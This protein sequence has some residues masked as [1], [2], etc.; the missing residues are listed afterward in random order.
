MT[1][2]GK[3]SDLVF[4]WLF[5]AP[6]FVL[7]VAFKV[8]PAISAVWHSF[9][10]WD[11]VSAP[12]Y[13]GLANYRE[14][15]KDSVFWTALRNNFV[16]VL[17]VPLWIT[18]SLILALLIHAEVPGW[19]FFRMAFFL[20]SVLS[21]VIVGT[22]FTALLRYDG[23]VNRA[24]EIV[25][26]DAI[27]RD[28]LG[29]PSTALPTLMLVIL[30]CIFGHGVIVFLAGLAAVPRSIFEAAWLDGAAGWVY[31]WHIVVPSLRHVIEFWAVNL[32]VWSFTSLFAFIYV[33]TGGGPGY[34]TTLVEYELYLKAFEANRM[35]YACALGSA[36]FLLVFGLIALQVRLMSR[37]ED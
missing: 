21:P 9:T 29:N 11:G 16:L 33:M 18:V 5:L 30:W 15:L 3:R 20:P 24:L 32:I 34:A 8:V 6:V 26:L 31:L 27:A 12:T 25:G 35:G 4:G 14:L 36:L 23:P 19:K 2:T 1:L 7:L 17:A 22:L 28:W 10:A 37:G 13:I